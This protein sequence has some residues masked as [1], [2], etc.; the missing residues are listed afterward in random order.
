MWVTVLIAQWSQHFRLTEWEKDNLVT[1]GTTKMSDPKEERKD[2]SK[3]K[4]GWKKSH[5]LISRKWPIIFLLFKE[6]KAQLEPK[7]L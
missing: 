7:A 2:V 4:E 3:E 5:A 6:A 1:Q